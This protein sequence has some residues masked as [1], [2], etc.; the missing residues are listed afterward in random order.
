[1]WKIV[2]NGVTVHTVGDVV[3]LGRFKKC[4]IGA[5]QS[6]GNVCWSSRGGVCH[7]V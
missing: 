7:V 3:V 1:M 6:V 4:C 5:V 2:G